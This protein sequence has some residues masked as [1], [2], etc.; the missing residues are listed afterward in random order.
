MKFNTNNYPI[1]ES[2]DNLEERDHHSMLLYDDPKYG[3][4][5]KN[6][7]IENGL[8]KGIHTICIT[9]DDVNFVEKEIA[10][11]GIDVDN[12]K[13]KNLLHIYQIG[14]IMESKDGL[15]S[16]Y[17]DMLKKLT[18]DSKP[19]YRFVGRTI[20]NIST[21]EGIEAELV[22]ENLFHSHFDSYPGSVLCPYNVAEIE[23]SKRPIWLQRLLEYHHNLIYASEP[24]KSV[25]FEPD[26]L[27]SA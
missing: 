11:T 5:V 12:F 2:L 18:V 3:I 9:H 7:F 19:P 17:N 6:R 26:L 13:R 22:L 15:T 20:A 24:E 21:N 14:N 27:N 16:A 1:L 10:S 4:L 8:Q 25:I 23:K